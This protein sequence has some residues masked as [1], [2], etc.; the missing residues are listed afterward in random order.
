MLSELAEEP[1]RLGPSDDKRVGGSPGNPEE[2]QERGR[3][4]ASILELLGLARGI[5]EPFR[6]LLVRCYGEVGGP[7]KG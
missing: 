5:P 7:P 1:L 2:R 4:V 6:Q 3:K